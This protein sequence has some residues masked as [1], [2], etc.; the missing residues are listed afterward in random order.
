MAAHSQTS[1]KRVV[2][3]F[4]MTDKKKVIL[5]R[6]RGMNMYELPMGAMELSARPIQAAIQALV[7]LQYVVASA[8]DKNPYEIPSPLADC[9]SSNVVAL[10][11]HHVPSSTTLSTDLIVELKTTED[12]HTLARQGRILNGYSVYRALDDLGLLDGSGPRSSLRMLISEPTG[13]K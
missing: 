4:A 10:G 8:S 13:P 9:A 7:H 12:V 3:I 5:V 1:L 11:C 2:N 6:R